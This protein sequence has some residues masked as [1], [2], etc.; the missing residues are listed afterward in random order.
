VA[1][2]HRDSIMENKC[3]MI[4]AGEASGDRHGAKLVDAMLARDKSLFFCGIGGRSLKRAGVRVLVESETLSVVGITEVV[5]KIPALLKGMTTAKRLLKSLKP[6]LLIIIDF[7]DFN[8]YVAAV[9]KKIG[10]PVLYYISPQVWAWRPNRIRKIGRVVDHVAVILPFEEEHF[11]KHNIP[12]TF[13]GHPLLDT[14]QELFPVQTDKNSGPGKNQV[15]GLLPGSRT[16]EIFHN[17]PA[18]IGS[19]DILNRRLTNGRFVISVAPSIKKGDIKKVLEKSKTKIQFELSGGGVENVFKQSSLVVAASGTVTLEAAIFGTPMIIIYKI[20]SVSYWLA[21]ALIRVGH[22]GL[23]N[24]IAGKEVVPELLQSDASPENIADAV[25][26]M[27]KNTQD[28]ETLKDE[29]TDVKNI[30]GGPG[31]AKRVADI[32]LTML[33][34]S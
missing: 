24:L 6:D 5:F 21:R 26:K 20:S 15:I 13:V 31:A 11:K 7:P 34:S 22:V 30:L 28:M 17:L 4:I 8:L 9:A 14:E 1:V 10:I 33:H 18:M 19:A 16:K 29:L 23:V 27:L 2:W 12:V 32:A 25:L 3:I